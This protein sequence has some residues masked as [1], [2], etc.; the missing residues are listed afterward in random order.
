MLY[1]RCCLDPEQSYKIQTKINT[2]LPSA[3]RRSIGAQR[4]FP[5]IE[6]NF[7]RR[8]IPTTIAKKDFS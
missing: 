3:F 6:D 4:D 5:D 7:F 8:G 2:G 1:E